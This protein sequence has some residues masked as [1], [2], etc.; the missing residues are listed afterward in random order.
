MTDLYTAVLADVLD[1]LGYRDQCLGSKVRALTDTGRVY[2]QVFTLRARPVNEAP[3]EPYKL[4]MAAID[5]ATDGDV[6]LIDAGYDQSCGFWG[7][8][9]TTACLA[10]GI[11]GVVMTACTRDRWA[12]NALSF[13]VFAIGSAP[14]DSLGR[15]DVVEIACPIEID[16][17]TARN[18][19]LIL[20]DQ[21]GVVIIP[22]QVSEQA[23]ALAR[24]KMAAEDTVRDEL[25]A[26]TPLSEVFSKHG[27]L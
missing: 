1:T 25:A 5:A 11:R 8:L 15:L 21:D 20:G 16:G 6:L 14:A 23:L 2:G 24:A 12:L 3:Q 4:E 19:D 13:P 26:G 27:I 22:Q 10:K 18:G 7:E 17:V 9:L